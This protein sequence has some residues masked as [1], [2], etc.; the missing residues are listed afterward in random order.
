VLAW[1]IDIDDALSRIKCPTLVLQ[2]REATFPDVSAARHIAGHISNAEMVLLEGGALLPWVGDM[3]EVVRVI[4]RFLGV[5]TKTDA[6]AAKPPAPVPPPVPPARPAAGGLVTI[7][8]TDIEGSTTMTQRAGDAAAQEIV[9]AHNSIVRKALEARG[10]TE[11]KHTGDGIMASFPLPSS[12][13][14]A[15]ID[16]QRDVAKNNAEHPEMALHVRV[17]LNAGEPVIED[18]DMFGTAVQL[19]RRVCDA[20]KP[21]TILVTDVVRQLAAGKGFLFADTG[22]ASLRGFEDPVRL[23]E[24]RWTEA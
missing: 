3:D 9:H 23:Y 16:I 21:G 2:R 18:E 20:A 10:G 19:A 4:N 5:E 14:E 6:S 17:G 22:E 1:D 12:A 7:L 8:F 13:I 11:T 15:A 24:V